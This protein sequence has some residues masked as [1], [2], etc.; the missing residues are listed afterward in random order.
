MPYTILG[1][2]LGLPLLLGLLFRVSTSH[3]FFSLMAGELLTR[4]FGEDVSMLVNSF[5]RSQLLADYAQASLIVLPLLLTAIFL[6][7]TLSRGKLI[8]HFAPLVVTGV[9]L[10]AFMLPELP[11]SAQ[12]QV[13][14][15]EAGSQLI[16]TST[17][18]IGGVVFLQL[19]AL[20]LLNQPHEGRKKHHK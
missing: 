10:A 8:F 19:V 9:V 2:V 1:A 16:N 5:A 3:L 7:G 15:I 20:W 11:A 12:A 18:I 4:Y 14:S 6:K 17:V 13:R